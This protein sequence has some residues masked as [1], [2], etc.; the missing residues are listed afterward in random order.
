VFVIVSVKPCCGGWACFPLAKTI[1]P[2]VVR[3]PINNAPNKKL[4]RF[5]TGS[6]R[7]VTTVKK[8]LA[9][10]EESATIRTVS[11]FEIATMV[12]E[13]NTIGELGR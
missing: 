10:I 1:Y 9:E 7:V 4:R 13:G 5:I 3:L 6:S 12:I 8:T 11:P 2:T